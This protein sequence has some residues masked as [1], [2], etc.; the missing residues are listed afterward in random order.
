MNIDAAFLRRCLDTL[1]HALAGLEGLDRSEIA[2]DIYRAAAVKQFELALEQA[3][4]LMKLR[5]RPWFA[6]NREADRLAFKD[7]FRHAAR[8]GIIDAGA[9]ERW[10]AWRDNR[11]V[12]AHDYGEGFAAVTLKLLP[13]FVADARALADIVEAANDG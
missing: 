10:F 5:L 1:E 6:S 11:N 8:R 9:C 7:V 4:K 13:A 12:T 3:G 2:Y